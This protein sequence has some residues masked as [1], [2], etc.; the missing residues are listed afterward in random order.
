[1][2]TIMTNTEALLDVS[3]K[4]SIEVNREKTKCMF[5]PYHHNGGQICNMKKS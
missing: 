4:V 2:I 1:M 3:K 5:M